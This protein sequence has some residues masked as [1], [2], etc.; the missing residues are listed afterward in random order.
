MLPLPGQSVPLALINATID[1]KVDE[2]MRKQKDV[3]VE[4]NTVADTIA[5]ARAMGTD[6]MAV[7]RGLI[8]QA[9]VMEADAAQ[10]RE[11]A[12]ALAPEL[13]PGKGRPADPV[14]VKEQKAEERRAA[15]REKDRAKA[16]AAKATKATDAVDTKV[17]AK[18]ARDNARAAKA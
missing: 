12:Y 5:A 6:P 13:K 2:Y 10:K 15:R 8:L 3:P 16:A 9:E 18:L 14:D 7:A 1:K 4:Q 11:E 17:S